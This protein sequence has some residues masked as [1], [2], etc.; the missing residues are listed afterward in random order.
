M[1]VHRTRT[2]SYS[3]GL[4]SRLPPHPPRLAAYPSVGHL[5]PRWSRPRVD[6][7]NG[8]FFA[9]W[10]H[11]LPSFPGILKTQSVSWGESDGSIAHASAAEVRGDLLF[12]RV[13]LMMRRRSWRGR[14]TAADSE[15]F[16]REASSLLP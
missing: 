12:L 10:L 16:F 14:R 13:V 9:G 2:L 5:V 11:D 7:G 6:C 8:D 4:I 1:L 15:R 3:T